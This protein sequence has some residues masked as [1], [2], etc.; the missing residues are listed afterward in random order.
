[1]NSRTRMRFGMM[2]VVVVVALLA[3]VVAF[4]A[5]GAAQTE[6]NNAVYYYQDTSHPGVCC[7]S[8]GAFIDASTFGGTG[9]TICSVLQN[10]LA[11]FVT[12]AGA[13]IDARGLNSTNTSFTC[14][15]TTP[16][17]WSGISN[18][19]PSTILLPATTASVPI[20]IPGTWILPNNTHLIGAGDN[21]PSSA[22]PSTTIQA[23]TAFQ[24][25]PGPMIQFGSS[26]LC[27]LTS[28]CTGISQAFRRRERSGSL[29]PK[30]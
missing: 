9:T 1:M 22:T 10:I 8:S 16:S 3:L 18:P 30:S 15:S 29:L 26:T 28:P 23:S 21:T 13:V 27:S 7:K 4:P 12:S 24:S 11:N 2:F 20:V 14:T 19:P 17:P 6:G 5:I 25:T